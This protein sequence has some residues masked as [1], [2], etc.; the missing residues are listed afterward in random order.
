MSLG[1]IGLGTALPPHEMSQA[2]A[3]AMTQEVVCRDERQH[4]LARMVFSK[5]GVDRRRTI[6][7]HSLA[8]EWTQIKD[9]SG[10][11]RGPSTGE[12][13]ALCEELGPALA[14]EAAER[15]LAQSGVTARDVT[16]LITVSCTTIAAPGTDIALFGSL[17]LRSDVERVNVGFMGCHGAINGL[18]VAQ[19]LVQSRPHAVV[20]LSALELCSLHYQFTWEDD[21]IIGNALFAD[22]SAAL[23]GVNQSTPRAD[24]WTVVD[25]GSC[26]LPDSRDA[27]TWKFGDSGLKMT[28]TSAVPIKIEQHL[29]RWMAS[30]LDRNGCS[31]EDVSHWVIHPGGPKI[32]TAVESALSLSRQQTQLSHELLADIGNISSPT[33]LF[34][35]ERLEREHPRGLCVMLGFGPGLVAEACLLYRN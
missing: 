29:G 26:L 4:R 35:L 13:M 30:W 8:Y 1:I 2:D 3:L 12:R 33:V 18:R 20:L 34:A 16:H 7:P 22:G 19:G 25:T 21:A 31:I 23:L 32:L 10:A 9:A 28:L 17:G 15:A 27:M 14:F 24:R 6:V 5:A 11:S